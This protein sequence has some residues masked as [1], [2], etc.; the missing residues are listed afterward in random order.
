MARIQPLPNALINQIAAGEVIERPASV[1]KELV[2]N[3]IDAHATQIDLDLEDGGSALIRVR[4]NGHGIIA[5]D[6]PLAFATHATSK[7]RT[8]DDLEHIQTLGFRG[9]ALP[10]IASVS[11]TTLIS[12]HKDSDLAYRIIPHISDIP[13]PIAHPIGTTI[14]IRDLFYNTPARKKFLKSE[15]TERYHIQQLIARLALSHQ[16]LSLT[17]NHHGKPLCHYTGNTPEERLISV[18]GEDMLEQSIPIEATNAHLRL[19]GW[20]GL[21]TYTHSQTDKQHF[22]INQRMIR[23]KVIVHAIKQGYQDVL[24]KSAHP[25]FVL[26]LELP[27]DW[28][29]VNAHPA[30]HEVRF[31]EPRLTHDFIYSTLNHALRGTRL[32]SAPQPLPTQPTP[33]ASQPN[34]P[35]PLSTKSANYPPS[36]PAT[37]NP[38]PSLAET[39]H[40]YQWA[41]SI[42]TPPPPPTPSPSSQ[43]HEHPL[44]YAIGHIHHIFILAQNQ[45]GLILVDT[46]AAHERILYE[47]LKAQLHSHSIARQHLLIAQT[48]D[49]TPEQSEAFIQHQPTLER[50]GFDLTL[51]NDIL[52]IDAVPER[53]KR[54][55]ISTLLQDLLTELSQYPSSTQLE[56]LHHQILSTLSCHKAI[57][58]GDPL[59]LSEM[60]QLLRDLEHTPA[61]AQCNHGRPT[62]VALSIDQLNQ[63]FMRGQ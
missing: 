54:A 30:K 49:L 56:H 50:L 24:H 42:P 53:L 23:D 29:D 21:P 47:R 20:V 41:Q 19:W 48:L 62:W 57:R 27:P 34:I 16:S 58:C 7:I 61:S 59:S 1:V 36:Y 38:T 15:R 44:G 28:I 55:D 13:S 60:N 3:A 46:H 9:E 12:R 14:E 52:T 6:L 37:K 31:R 33:P 18:M 4:D 10:S 40:Y 17:L 51:E 45:Q 43:S 2:E 5:E 8:F 11:K 26:H 25:I 63:F 32:P 35:L 22:F 39:R